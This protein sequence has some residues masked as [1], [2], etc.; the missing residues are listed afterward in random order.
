MDSKPNISLLYDFYG[1][2]LKDSQK[3]V[4]EL[5][6]NEDLSL[7]EVAEILSI[8][9]QGVRDALHRAE[10]KLKEYEEKLG[11]LRQHRETVETARRIIAS[12]EKTET[13][14]SDEEAVRLLIQ[15]RED[16]E[17]L[18]GREE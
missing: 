3:N 11:L 13:L 4:V 17:K 10:R 5:C 1:D 14:T 2:L 15:I 12:S 6:V 16:A 7:S 18:L 8:S 9:R